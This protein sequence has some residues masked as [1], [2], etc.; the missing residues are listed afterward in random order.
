M[1]FAP[2]L[3]VDD[4]SIGK[5]ELQQAERIER[6]RK[7]RGEAEL[8]DEYVALTH[9]Y[10]GEAM[11]DAAL[12]RRTLVLSPMIERICIVD[13]RGKMR[14]LARFLRDV[15]MPHMRS[16][17][18]TFGG[19][20]SGQMPLA[21]HELVDGGR[22]ET[23]YLRDDTGCVCTD[24][25]PFAPES[26]TSLAELTLKNSC[27]RPSAAQRL[28]ASIRQLSLDGVWGGDR[29]LPWLA[30]RL[31]SYS[32]A[33]VYEA[34]EHIGALAA[35]TEL[36]ALEVAAS[37]P[38]LRALPPIVERLSQLQD[39]V[40]L[41]VRGAFELS[42]VL[43]VVPRSLHTLQ[44]TFAR[45]VAGFALLND[46]L[47]RGLAEHPRLYHVDSNERRFVDA[48]ARRA[49]LV[50]SVLDEHEN[51]RSV[52]TNRRLVSLRMRMLEELGRASCAAGTRASRLMPELWD[53]IID[54]LPPGRFMQ[55]RAVSMFRVG[56]FRAKKEAEAV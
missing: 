56:R 21:P 53:E 18:V 46:G 48:V 20:E 32:C 44:V 41:D 50:T 38:V 34:D 19:R 1:N 31:T 26:L 28:P 45:P 35:A 11:R 16:L 9:L 33:Y 55:G 14:E 15:P 23:L 7:R 27:L 24:V 6:Q 2:M 30:P 49:R 43:A 36:R 51:A 54:Q 29:S 39:L 8:P 10:A 47:R 5:R 3:S 12:L 42:R 52:E 40:I 4:R 17:S 37:G 25:E 13:Y 22:L